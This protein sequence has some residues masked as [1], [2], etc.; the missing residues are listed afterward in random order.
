MTSSGLRTAANGGTRGSIAA[1]V[2]GANSGISIPSA[3]ARSAMRSQAPPEA[4]TTP[5]R[6][7]AGHR[8]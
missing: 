4:V 2:C 6:R 3:A 5:M 8:S 7:P 1:T